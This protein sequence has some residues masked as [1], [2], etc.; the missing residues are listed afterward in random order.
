MKGKLDSQLVIQMIG[1]TWDRQIATYASQPDGPP[2]G[3]PADICISTYTQI[4]TKTTS[5]DISSKLRHASLRCLE[6]VQAAMAMLWHCDG[7]AMV[8][9]RICLYIIEDQSYDLSLR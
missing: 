9:R 5:H 6:L 3:G 1:R 7:N 8:P 2:K 4:Y